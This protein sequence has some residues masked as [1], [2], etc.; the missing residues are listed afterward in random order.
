VRVAKGPICIDVVS[1]LGGGHNLAFQK[2]QLSVGAECSLALYTVLLGGGWWSPYLVREEI[3]R[4]R[5]LWKVSH[6][7]GR[8]EILV[9]LLT[10]VYVNILCH[11]CF[12]FFTNIDRLGL[13]MI[14]PRS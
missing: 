6:L 12:F 11:R 3:V 8:G 5:A 1:T 4:Q 13:H 9:W 14:K 7:E 10:P 2:V